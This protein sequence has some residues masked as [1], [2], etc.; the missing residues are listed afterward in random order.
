[1]LPPIELPGPPR[2]FAGFTTA[3]KR[4]ELPVVLGYRFQ[5][6]KPQSQMVLSFALKGLSWI[7]QSGRRSSC[8]HIK[9]E[10]VSSF[11]CCCSIAKLC[12][13][14]CDPMDC[15]MPFY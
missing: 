7:V 5:L 14:L 11:C 4:S 12:P 15:S 13:T 9:E 8:P 6:P 1:M 3:S 10:G 2:S